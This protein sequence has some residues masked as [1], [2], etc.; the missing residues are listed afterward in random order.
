MQQGWP[1]F[2]LRAFA[3]ILLIQLAVACAGLWFVAASGF[4][5]RIEAPP[6]TV[7]LA[8]SVG[9]FLFSICLLV[10]IGQITIL[11]SFLRRPIAAMRAATAFV[12][13]LPFRQGGR[14][15]TDTTE[16][17]ELDALLKALN[18]TAA[19]LES[20][21]KALSAARAGEQTHKRIFETLAN[22]APLPEVLAQIALYVEQ[23]NPDLIC[24]LFVVDDSG[25]HLLLQAAPSLSPEYNAVM[26]SIPVREGVCC[27]GTAAY[28]CER[29]AIENIQE[30]PHWAAQRPHVV[31]EGLVSCWAEPLFSS[32]R[33][34][35]GT[36]AIY[37]RKEALPTPE[38]FAL[39]QDAAN[40]A[41]VAIERKRTEEQLHLAAMVYSAS[42]EAIFVSDAS[43]YLIA[44]NPAFEHLTG[45]TARE[46]IGRPASFLK[47]ERNPPELQEKINEA[48]ETTGHWQG[49]VWSRRKNGEIYAE[50]L[51][52]TA[53]SDDAGNPRYRVALFSDITEKKNTEQ[54]V[55]LQANNDALTNLPN[56]RLFRDRLVQDIARAAR[57][58][59]QI[60][61]LFLDLDH[62][63]QV[64]DVLGHD[65]GD[66]LLIE[67]SQRI[68]AC[69][70]DSDTV[71][72]LGGDEFTVILYGGDCVAVAERVCE[73]MLASLTQ[74]FVL[75]KEKAY[76]S[77]SIGIT[78]YPDDARDIES[79]LKNA[80]QAMYAAKEIGRNN[81]SW[82]TAE[83]QEAAQA[84]HALANDLRNALPHG[85]L[86]LYFQPIIDLENEHPI[87]AEALLRWCHPSRGLVSPDEFIPIAEEIGLISDIGDWVLGEALRQAQH[88]PTVGGQAVSLSINKSPREFSAQDCAERWLAE[89]TSAGF[90][91]TR[92]IFEITEGT[93]IQDRHSVSEKLGRL[94]AAGIRIAI[95]DFG[96]GYSSLA[97]LKKF[98][99]DFLKIDRSFVR[100]ISSDSSDRALCEAIITIANLMDMRVVAEGVETA[101]QRDFLFNVGCD[102][103]QGYLYSPPLSAWD[104][105]EYL[106]RTELRLASRVA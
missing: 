6:G 49:D 25:T 40:L 98:P 38:A 99:I 52:I 58:R 78:L 13:T 27:S 45:Y 43:D 3:L 106:R 35:L 105:V 81:Y 77:A 33:E 39:I 36:F 79:L 75:G 87:K 76:I 62:F 19:R 41:S 69:V 51:T 31:R 32:Q 5:F 66:T 21:D 55:W 54:A 63:K 30:H 68:R 24:S 34:L 61:L 22:A 14:L 1:R 74:P 72:R 102:Y 16:L 12:K 86:E 96:T 46:V 28:R 44:V 71:A 50:S 67:A 60:A 82:F 64:N 42:T 104:F 18:A 84:R 11:Y 95:D 57:A 29:V 94:R 23:Q 47:A 89:L 15:V 97:Y 4:P 100:D 85:E 53:I 2:L 90:E 101:A 92:M 91:A 65:A 56:R 8:F 37:Q 10:V 9:L 83:L 73:Q 88:W 17:G 103:C 20:Q 80:D 48:L 59:Q 70:R 26:L 93:I 7:Y